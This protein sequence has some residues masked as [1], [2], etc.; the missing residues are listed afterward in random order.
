QFSYADSANADWVLVIGERDLEE[1]VV[2]IR[3]MDSGKEEQISRDR[4]QAFFED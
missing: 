1:D 3:D 4:V 2:T